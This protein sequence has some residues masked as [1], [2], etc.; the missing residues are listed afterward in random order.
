MVSICRAPLRVPSIRVTLLDSCGNVVESSC[1][2]VATT[3]VITIEQTDE[4]Q[5]RMDYTTVNADNAL[6]ITDTASPQLKWANVTISFCKVDPQLF[7]MMS[8]ESV[9]L[10]D[11]TTPNVIGFGTDVGSAENSF[12]ALEAWTRLSGDSACEGGTVQYGYLLYPFLKQG[13]ITF[14]TFQ[15]G[16]ATF[17][18]NAISSAASLWG[19]G[20]YNIQ[21]IKSGVNAG[22]PTPLYAAIGSTRHRQLQWV[23]LAPPPGACG[24]VALPQVLTV[25]ATGA[26]AHPATVTFPTPTEFTLPAIIDWG[27]SSTSTV[28]SGTSATHNYASAGAYTVTFSPTGYSYAPWSGSVTVA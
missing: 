22:N 4:L 15:N 28:T 16:L 27:D 18:V 10:D 2:S 1:S 25:A 13:M 7:S 23:D 21:T 24:C 20:P 17:Q 11:D 26:G 5:E 12:F 3:G 6:C 19:V 8:G 14:P 9:V